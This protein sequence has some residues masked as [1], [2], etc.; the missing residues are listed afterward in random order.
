[1]AVSNKA[2]IGAVVS[3][4]AGGRT[5]LRRIRSGSSFASS[6]E[7]AA[8]F[9]LGRLSRA[10]ELRVRWPTGKEE[11]YPVPGLDRTLTVEEG[12]GR[13]APAP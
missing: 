9:G 7:I 4:R 5:Q 10:D 12:K 11:V 3:L 6:S 8:R 1:G 13:P 2:G